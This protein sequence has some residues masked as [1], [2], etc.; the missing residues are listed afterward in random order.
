MAA[1]AVDGVAVAEPMSIIVSE[2]WLPLVVVQDLQLNG[3]LH[4]PIAPASI[5]TANSNLVWDE[6][7]QPTSFGE[8]RT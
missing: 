8:I 1:I 3:V 5:E 6:I 2:H 4:N 7:H